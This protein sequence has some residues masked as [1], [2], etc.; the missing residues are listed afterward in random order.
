MNRLTIC[1]ALLLIT[2]CDTAPE[3]DTSPK[4]LPYIGHY[5]LDYSQNNGVQTV[6]TV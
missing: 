5:D 2:G 1:L 6:D 4:K 3:K